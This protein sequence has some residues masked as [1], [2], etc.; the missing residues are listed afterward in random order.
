MSAPK[1]VLPERKRYLDAYEDVR[2]QFRNAIGGGFLAVLAIF[3]I[4]YALSFFE[5]NFISEYVQT[6]E[7]YSAGQGVNEVLGFWGMSFTPISALN[8]LNPTWVDDWIVYLAPPLVAGLVIALATR[9]L[10]YCLIGSLWFVVWGMVLPLVFVFV[11]PLFGSISFF[12]AVNPMSLN[13][14]LISVFQDVLASN[15]LVVVFKEMTSSPYL[16]WVM[17]GTLE[18]GGIVTLFSLPF[19]AIFS[20]L[21]VITRGRV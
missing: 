17:A 14:A 13:G 4:N 7:V 20:L 3:V 19:G 9:S 21:K 1:K 6:F 8:V 11:L 10:K 16:G 5:D 15:G 12:E 2:K 18:I